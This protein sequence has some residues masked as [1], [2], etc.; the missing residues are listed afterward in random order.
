MSRQSIL[1][2]T[3]TFI[4]K[5]KSP[6]TPGKDYI[7]ASG[8]YID[9]DDIASLVDSA[10]DG[11]LTEGNY[12]KEFE[13]DLRT[14]FHSTIRHVVLTNSG[15]S[16]NLLAVTTITD[17]VHGN[18]RAKSGD[19]I[20][21]VSAGFP[22]TVNP[23]LQNGLVPVFVDVDLDTFTPSMDV[24][25]SAIIE[26]QTK[27]IILA[28]PLG[29]PFDAET[30]RDICDEYGIWFI[31]DSCDG[32]GGTLNDRLLG[33]FGDISTLSF[34]PAHHIT[35]GEG[36]ACLL[37]SPFN[38]KV[39]KSYRDWGRDC[40]CD[41]GKENTCGKRFGHCLG[42][43][44]DGYDHK[45]IYSRIGYNLKITDMQAALLVSQLKKLPM[46]VEKRRQNWNEL[47]TR[48]DKYGKYL[49]F[50]QT[51][52]GASPSWFGFSIIVKEFAPFSRNELIQFL[53]QHQIGTRL[54]FGGNL[55]RQP[56]YLDV[57]YKIYQP[58]TN[59]DVI[60][61][62]SFWVGVHPSI[63]EEQL[64]YMEKVFGQFFER[65]K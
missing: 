2:Q 5:K 9:G 27:G 17:K 64:D 16:A 19:E 42:D 18:R 36:G 6:F 63:G 39:L 61:R 3:R 8:K 46:F 30:L 56:A 59:S 43:L 51:I 48:L 4:N 53:E 54:L 13:K 50:M 34:Y 24:I 20:I 22:T 29:N 12:A 1:G 26:G 60:M 10:L 45:Y 52:P 62:D 14:Y 31:E 40:W 35:A 11:W 33:S 38:E 47:R 32:L 58:L 65:Y 28:H 7:P 57:P 23:I 15:S 25:E 44:P 41:T 21:T 37:Q 49:R 55:T